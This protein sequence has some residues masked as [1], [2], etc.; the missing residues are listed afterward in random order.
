MK[1]SAKFITPTVTPPVKKTKETLSEQI[2]TAKILIKAVATGKKQMQ[3]ICSP[4]GLGKTHL[5]TQELKKHGINV[6]PQSPGNP[7]AFVTALYHHRNKPVILFDDCEKLVRSE[8][9]AN[10]AKMAFGSNT[11]LVVHQTK[12]IMA[13]ERLL[14]R[15]P[16]EDEDDFNVRKSRHK[17][18]MQPSKFT[19][20]C[21]LIMLSNIDLTKDENVSAHMQAHFRA[22]ISRGLHPYW[23]E[24]TGTS[25]KETEMFLYTLDLLPKILKS[26]RIS[27]EKTER[28]IKWFIEKRNYLDEIVPRVTEH[29]GMAFDIEESS[30]QLEAVLRPLMCYEKQRNIPEIIAPQFVR[31]DVW[32]P[33]RTKETSPLVVSTT[34]TKKVPVAKAKAIQKGG[35]KKRIKK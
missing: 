15:D 5:V 9:I 25:E 11:R 28:A 34:T 27:R 4:A 33:A 19:V 7:D 16:G 31:A 32:T 14:I 26:M 21:R 20:K 3:L 18:N 10:K 6:E 1:T 22:L 24:T 35:M 17:S 23:I 12:E 30:R 29:I 8:A 13:N 2:E